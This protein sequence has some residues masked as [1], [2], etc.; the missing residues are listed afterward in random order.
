MLLIIEVGN[1]ISY[2]IIEVIK[3]LEDWYV[4]YINCL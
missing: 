2:V 3:V 4:I 1:V